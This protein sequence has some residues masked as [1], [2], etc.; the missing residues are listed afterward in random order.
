MK[1]SLYKFKIY[2]P[3]FWTKVV[4]EK[5]YNLSLVHLKK[6]K[7]RG[8]KIKTLDKIRKEIAKVQWALNLIEELNAFTLLDQLKLKPKKYSW[9]EAKIISYQIFEKFEEISKKLKELKRKEIEAKLENNKEI[10][11]KIREEIKKL[12]EEARNADICALFAYK[13]YLENKER[14]Y[15]GFE[16]L[17][18][19][20]ATFFA[21]GYFPKDIAIKLKKF[22]LVCLLL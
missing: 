18:R 7:G 13:E 12:K 10:L 20:G 9:R 11:Y 6:A 22:S 19:F 5:L 2:F 8:I 3:Y 21:K 17:G 15:E 16:K 1:E 4:M 14:F